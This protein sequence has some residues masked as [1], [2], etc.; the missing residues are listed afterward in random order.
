MVERRH[1][2]RRW[3]PAH[4]LVAERPRAGIS[5]APVETAHR[6]NGL[7]FGRDTEGADANFP[8]GLDEAN[9]D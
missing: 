6:A 1:N 5:L 4:V 2:R 7:E 8:F 3:E 9:I